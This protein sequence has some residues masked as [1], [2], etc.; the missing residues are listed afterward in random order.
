MLNWFKKKKVPEVEISILESSGDEAQDIV[1]AFIDRMA[2]GPPHLGDA[3]TLPHSKTVL[4][5]AFLEQIQHYEIMRSISEEKFRSMG[6]DK[7][8]DQLHSM[9]LM[10]AEWHDIDAEDREEVTRL[11]A[12]QG[13]PP[14]WAMPMILKY[15][16]RIDR[17]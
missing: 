15:W 14:E 9:Y 16:Q 1:Y 10:I 7:T 5:A 8:V 2:E 3:A 17:A 11:N 6:Y 12:T 4:R 13:P